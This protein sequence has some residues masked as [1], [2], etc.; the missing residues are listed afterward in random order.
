M[1]I[2]NNEEALEEIVVNPVDL[3][4]PLFS[5]GNLLKIP[6]TSHEGKGGME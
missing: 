3:F 1:G 2:L 5:R 4:V 6:F